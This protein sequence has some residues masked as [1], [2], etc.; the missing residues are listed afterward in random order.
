MTAATDLDKIAADLFIWQAY[1]RAAN[2]DLFTS[3]I[4]TRNGIFVVDPIPLRKAAFA[5]FHQEGV[6]AGVVITN[7]NHLR[8]S[9]QFAKQFSVPIFAHRAILRD[10]MPRQFSELADGEKICDEL[11]VI[12]IDGAAPGEIA[13]HCASGDG[14]LIMGDALINFQPYG[15]T[16]L[17]G[18]YCSN[19][20]EMR[21][22]LRKLLTCKTQRMLFAHGLPIL[23]RATD[24][25]HQL[26]DGDL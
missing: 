12:G 3:A 14:T 8:A 7:T 2:S 6:I 18:K 20:K 21:R 19:E 5:Q 4:V 22:S 26:L 23:S 17:P 9:G 25:L 16:F 24:R 10:T 1:D 15:F 11:H 13:L